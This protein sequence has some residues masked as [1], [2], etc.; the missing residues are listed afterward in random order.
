MGGKNMRPLIGIS[1]GM[2]QAIYSMTQDNPPQLQHR[3]NESYV[4][5]VTRAGGVPVILPNNLD[6]STAEEIAHSLDGFL[7]SGG[8]DVDPTLF[9]ER[10]TAKLGTVTPRR[11]NF[12]LS[13]AQYI[14]NHTKKPVLGICRGIQVM[15]VAMGGSLHID[16]PADGKLC[17]SMNMFPRDVYSHDVEIT[18]DT[19]MAAIMGAGPGRVNSFHHQAIK[20]LGDGLVVSAV[21][22]PDEV[23]EAVELPGDRFVVGVQWHPEE[24]VA[25]P[26]AAAL[27]ARFVEAARNQK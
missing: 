14:L 18:S 12:E 24:L 19:R 9:G 3:L 25:C 1:C 7:L 13:L 23:I 10:A 26:E 8:G 11:D 6:L 2:G 16:L 17:H 22:V 20:D 4:R 21:S 15:N 27:F 5:A